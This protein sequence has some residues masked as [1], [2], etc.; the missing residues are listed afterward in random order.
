MA[1]IEFVLRKCMLGIFVD[2]DDKFFRDGRLFI[3][4]RDEEVKA[5]FRFVIV[6]RRDYS[7]PDITD[8]K[9]KFFA[10]GSAGFDKTVN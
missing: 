6:V 8:D 2:V 10:T 5:S 4:I 3:D 7:S 1:E 9:P